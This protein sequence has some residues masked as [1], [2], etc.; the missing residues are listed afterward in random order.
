MS[1]SA[2]TP[3][4]ERATTSTDRPEEAPV[5]PAIASGPGRR[6]DRRAARPCVVT[7]VVAHNG[8]RW[9]ADLA[10]ALAAQSRAPDR[11]VVVDTGSRDDTGVALAAALP[12][13][14]IVS[15]DR[16]TSFGA[17]VARGASTGWAGPAT[18]P[19][20]STHTAAGR[21]P[22]AAEDTWL[23]VLHDDCVPAPDALEALLATAAEDHRVGVVG[24][25][26]RDFANRRQLLEVG[27]TIARSGRRETRLEPGEE[28]QGQHDDVGR[29]LAVGSAGMLVRR[30]VWEHLG[31]F[32]R[33][34][35]L[36]RDD[37]DLGWRANLAGY[38]VAVAPDAVVY[39]VQAAAQGRRTIDAATRRRHL[40]DRRNA[41][42]VLLANLRASSLWLAY[43]RLALASVA[44][45]VGFAL[46]KLPGLAIDELLAVLLVVGR[47]DQIWRA[48]RARRELR[49]VHDAEV[50]TLLAP[51]GAQV[52]RALDS[53]A[54]VF[55]LGSPGSTDISAR[56]HRA[57][58]T[59]PSDDEDFADEPA[60]F[61]WLRRLARP[62]VVLF[63]A[64]AVITL[65]AGR[66]LLGAGRLVGG[67]L[68]P[69]PDGASDLWAT[70]IGSWHDV[71]L[72]SDATAPPYLA[73][74]AALGSLLL[75]KAPLAVEVLLVASVPLAGLT[76]LLAARRLLESPWVRVWAAATY[77]MLPATT[78]AIAGGRIG[79]AVATVLL[80]LLGL[81]VARVV[82]DGR[83]AGTWAS[84]W[85]SGLCLAVMAAFVPVAYVIAAALLLV[86]AAGAARSVAVLARL[87][88][89]LAT[90]ILVLV[91][92][93]LELPRRPGLLLLEAGLPGPGLSDPALPPVAIL[94]QSSG[95][96]GSLP[97]GLGI[98]LVLGALS[99][100]LS[101]HRRRLV[102]AGWATAGTGLAVGLAVS[103]T[104]VST[105]TAQTA[106]AA[107]PGFP[108][109]VVAGG[110]LLACAVGVERA[111]D[112]LRGRSFGW[113]QPVA[114]AIAGLVVV[115]PL[116]LAGWWVVRGTDEPLVRRDP[117]VLPPF[118]A[119]EGDEAARPRTVTL[120]RAAD[121]SITYAL[122]RDSGPRLGDAETGPPYE[123][124]DALD[125]AVADLVSGRGGDEARVLA[126][127][128]VRYL[129]VA[130]PVDED[131]VATIDA[132]PGLR[133][134]STNDGAA[135]WRLSQPASRLRLV[136]AD[137]AQLSE[138]PA[139][140]EAATATVPD[141]P[142]GR[143][144]V[145]AER[146]D[147]HWRA[148]LDGSPLLAE[149]VDGW[150][151]GFVL[152][153]AGGRLQ[154]T[155]DGSERT[156]WLTV[157]A[158][159]V[160]LVVLLATPGARR[161]ELTP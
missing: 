18:T 60:G 73:A 35:P 61:R 32:D 7:V 64:L 57:V 130:A 89:V 55:S 154:I 63:T 30:D 161:T 145:L 151:Q 122:L 119:A 17:A 74:V 65:V 96:P 157:Q 152:P 128:A 153:D 150:A 25:K 51:R 67:A 75:G 103:L 129:L 83:R 59:G 142:S 118:V 10:A 109:A 93:T 84:A 132:V 27:V 5:E 24:P 4:H 46:G 136:D 33:H 70:Y 160:G 19:G 121:G 100:L 159:L 50:E 9:A 99:S 37:V 26:V 124:F 91:P 107:W 36:F 120:D 149:T 104:T 112:R 45:A 155:Y 72:G 39:H 97:W 21:T 140:A 38:R 76:A 138:L 143:L 146:A 1:D 139:G 43:P 44:R 110:L 47:P 135:L 14:E 29:V 81:G 82:G 54:G 78:G 53:L 6:G 15:M 117:V 92:W 141:G 49:T 31:G 77:A 158:G 111:Q 156:R 127:H 105:P 116:V 86:V 133:R 144:V 2:P 41:L 69:A 85:A 16:R 147:L 22:Q 101:Q 123:S 48:R 137:G 40:L 62:G 90:P 42:Y 108:V 114:L 71:G 52:A 12:G 56:G 20:S 87:A 88:V 8:E 13:A 80:P 148:A 98:P 3:P 106:V 113:R 94:L 115:V 79:T 134:L 23:W 28:D 68:L 34:L 95:G 66:D 58:E 126:S 11:L 102:L 125:V 131:L